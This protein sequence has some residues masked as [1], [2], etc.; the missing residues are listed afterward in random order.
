MDF[1]CK[2]I[3]YE[4]I[5]HD[6]NIEK[7]EIIFENKNILVRTLLLNHR[8]PC[9]GFIITEKPK[10][11]HIKPEMLDFYN[12]PHHARPMLR[13]G[14]DYIT[15][16]GKIIS[17]EHLTTPPERSR[18]YAYCSD[19]TPFPPIIKKIKNIDLLYHEAT[20]ANKE[21]KRAEET[22]HS[23]AQQAATIARDAEVKRLIIGHFSSRYN[24]ENILLNEACEIF[25]YTELAKENVTFKIL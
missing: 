16:D 21:W 6:I 5:L 25:P 20:F 8:I 13:E 1:F 12:I 7:E 3:G 15:P 17:N 24:E 11:R 4:V 18:S 9:C 22:F 23:T 10:K 19:T 14:K 2:N